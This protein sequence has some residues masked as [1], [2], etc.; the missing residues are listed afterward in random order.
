M[1]GLEIGVLVVS[2]IVITILLI[3]TGRRIERTIFAPREAY[4]EAL[5]KYVEELRRI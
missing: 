5:R 1:S 3:V 4:V 2:A